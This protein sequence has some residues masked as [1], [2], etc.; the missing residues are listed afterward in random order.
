MISKFGRKTVVASAV[1]ALGTVGSAALAG[2]ALAGGGG[3]EGTGG[4]AGNGG[5]ANANCAVPI[6]L[7]LGVL[8]QGGPIKQ[9]N[10]TAGAGGTGG[11]GVTY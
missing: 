1:V 5:K 8:G 11:G 9:C 4:N 2:T 6:G 10:A 3:V 7:S